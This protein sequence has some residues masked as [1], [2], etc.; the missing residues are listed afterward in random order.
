MNE[1]PFAA[2]F[3]ARRALLASESDDT[4]CFEPLKTWS[5]LPIIA[6]CAL[7]ARFPLRIGSRY[8]VSVSISANSR[9]P[10]AMLLQSQECDRSTL[11]SLHSTVFHSRPGSQ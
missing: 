2:W 4:A 9:Q 8:P 5:G 1:T 10:S 7:Y 3:T 6:L 11:N